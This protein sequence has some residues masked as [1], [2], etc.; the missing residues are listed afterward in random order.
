MTDELTVLRRKIDGIDKEILKLLTQRSDIVSQVAQYK[1]NFPVKIRPAREIQMSWY[2]SEYASE[3]Y[4]APVLQRIWREIITSTLT[5][6][7]GFSVALYF[8]EAKDLSTSMALWDLTRDH[9]GTWCALYRQKDKIEIIEALARHEVELAVLPIKN[10]S[11]DPTPWWLYLAHRLPENTREEQW[12]PRISFLMP[13]SGP[14]NSHAYLDIQALALSCAQPENSGHDE[15]IYCI[16]IAPEAYAD[17]LHF[18]SKQSAYE[19][20]EMAEPN[21]HDFSAVLIKVDGYKGDDHP[22]ILA[23]KQALSPFKAS[24]FWLGIVGKIPP[25]QERPTYATKKL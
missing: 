25:Y 2:L 24:V 18:M 4:P 9:F 23:L 6:E 13:F 17:F 19:I 16:E 15:S 10:Q 8:D 14:S 7:G 5:L 1:K 22:E 12:K 11:I 3:A 20:I 21:I